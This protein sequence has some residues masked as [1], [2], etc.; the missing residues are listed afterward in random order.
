MARNRQNKLR[1][2]I[3]I[4]PPAP[5]PDPEVIDVQAIL[6]EYLSGNID[7]I[8][9]L[10]PTASGKTRYAVDLAHQLTQ[11]GGSV[12]SDNASL[13]SAPPPTSSAVPPLTWPRVATVAEGTLPP[14]VDT[15]ES[16]DKP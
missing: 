10:G 4:P 12:P 15:I 3:P 6:N 2:A 9:V 13:R 7:L 1:E 14:V 8:V 5:L 11:A 16:S